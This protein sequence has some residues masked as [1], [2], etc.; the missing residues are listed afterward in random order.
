M[1]YSAKLS[2]KHYKSKT[3]RG[4]SGK[5]WRLLRNSRWHDG[6]SPL[7]NDAMGE[8]GSA[9]I[10]FALSVPVLLMLLIGF[11]QFNLALYTSQCL[12]E[13]ARE[14][15]RWASMRGATSC[16]NTPYLT[17]CEAT[18]DEI[19][20]HAKHLGYPAIIPGNL[21]VSTSWLSKGGSTNAS[22]SA[23]NGQN[24]NQPGDAV[25]VVV[26]YQFPI[27]IPVAGSNTIQLSSTAQMVISQ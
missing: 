11:I 1:N 25:R 16:T 4:G 24:C 2:A 18:A 10:E 20:S 5:I 27:D 9:L 19:Q 12:S 26:R 3:A 17:E 23:C 7:Q 21:I 15:S 13:I 6:V 8:R 14:T 22:W